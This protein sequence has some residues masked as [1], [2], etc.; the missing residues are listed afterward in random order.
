MRW[1]W[2]CPKCGAGNIE[3][4]LVGYEPLRCICCKDVF[5]RDGVVVF[6]DFGNCD[7]CPG[8]LSFNGV[9]S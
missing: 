7:D 4:V 2:R 9:W 3:Q 5:L 1:I 8:Q 6:A